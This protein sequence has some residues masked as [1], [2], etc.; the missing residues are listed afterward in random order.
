[1]KPTSTAPTRGRARRAMTLLEITISTALVS[2]VFLAVF[3]IIDKGM[4]FYRLNTEANDCQ[5]GVLS[6]LSRLNS[7]LQNSAPQLIFIDS[8]A[9][10]PSGFGSYPNSRGI[11]Y[12]SPFDSSG[13]ARFDTMRQLYWQGYGCFYVDNEGQMRYLAR[14]AAQLTTPNQE[15]INPPPPQDA[16]PPVVPA[17]FLSSKQGLLLAKNITGLT[18]VKHDKDEVQPNGRKSKK[19]FY[20]VTVECGRKGDPLGYWIQ[21]HSSFFPRN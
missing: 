1:M 18:F 15:T 3:L 12:A 21:L 7:A 4:R 13:K 9:P 10:P 2:I 16:A 19:A 11:S 5:R 14:F 8:P 6:F 17:S 20:E